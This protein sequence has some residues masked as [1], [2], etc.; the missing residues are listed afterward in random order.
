MEMLM[1]GDFFFPGDDAKVGGRSGTFFR[2]QH[3]LHA[4][5]EELHGDC[6]TSGESIHI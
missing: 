2:F 6:E 1:E 5:G 4:A 3:G